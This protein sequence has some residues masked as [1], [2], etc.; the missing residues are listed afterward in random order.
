MSVTKHKHQII[1]SDAH[2]T[3]DAITRGIS[4]DNSEKNLLIQGDHNS[5]KFTFA[6]PRYIDGHDMLLC[7]HVQVAYINTQTSGRS[8]Q[9]STGVYLV[10]DL[11]LH[12]S[13]KDYLQC[14]WVI[15]HNATRYE[16]ALNFM[17]ILSCMEGETVT[18]RWK[19]NVFEGIHIAVSL[20]SDLVFEDE[21]VDII[22]QWKNSVMEYFAELVNIGMDAK[23][24]NVKAELHETLTNE[25]T[26]LHESFATELTGNIHTSI[27]EVN[28][29]LTTEVDHMHNAIDTFDDILETEI[30]KMDGDIDVLK[31]RMD[32]FTALGEGSTT[33]D[34]ELMDIRVGAD[35]KTYAN[36]G[37]AVRGQFNK[38]AGLSA[39][40]PTFEQ[41]TISST[42][43]ENTENVLNRIR[44]GYMRADNFVS[45]TVD[46]A[47]IV[48]LFQYNGDF[49][50][51]S[52]SN[53]VNSLD[54]SMLE[55]D[56][57]YIR[58]A[59]ARRNAENIT[60]DVDTGFTMTSVGS[61]VRPARVDILGEKHATLADRLKYEFDNLYEFFRT[62]IDF[63][64][65]SITANNGKNTDAMTRVR[66]DYLDANRFAVKI[67]SEYK[68]NLFQYTGA[69]EF[70]S[71]T[72]FTS[73]ISPDILQADC[74]YIR[75]VVC[76]SDDGAM[77]LED[78]TGFE[79]YIFGPRIDSVA[80]SE[81]K[82]RMLDA[83]LTI[84]TEFESGTIS[85]TDG[86]NTDNVKRIRSG[87][88]TS[89]IDGVRI[90]PYYYVGLF[91]YDVDYKFISSS[92]F[93]PNVPVDTIQE[94]CVH[95]RLVLTRADGKDIYPPE[96][97]HVTVYG[98]P[99]TEERLYEQTVAIKRA[100]PKR[101][102]ND[103]IMNTAYSTIGLAPINT[104]EHFH[105]AAHL[106]F[107]SLKGDVR[108]TADDELIMCHDAG[109]TLNADGRIGTYNASN[110]IPILETNYTDLMTLEYSADKISLG[111]YSKVC[112][113]D[114]FIRICKET[115]KIAYITL[116]E[117][118]ILPLVRG[119]IGTLEKYRM[120]NHC[121]INSYTLETLKE[122]RRYSDS[123]PLS[124][125]IS[126]GT[127]LTKDIVDKVVPLGN[128]I[129]TMFLYPTDNPDE[130]WEQSS[131]ALYYADVNDVQIHMAQ[132][133][134]YGDYSNMNRKGVQG[135]HLMKPFLAYNRSDV[136]FTVTVESRKAWF[137][138]ILNSTRYNADIS[139]NDGI[140]T[141]TNIRNNGSGY[142]Y[143]D[144]LPALWLNKLPFQANVT[145]STNP[146]CTVEVKNGAV[147][148][149]TN[150]VNGTYYVHVNI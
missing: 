129:I 105:L 62:D 13:K 89:K 9:Y 2:F 11:E 107:N 143:D 128:S 58:I 111:H 48:A 16:G 6:I 145:C 67:G 47:F 35:G 52:T 65:G 131:E 38:L 18:Y 90:H 88:L 34:A 117:N 138:N 144:G 50:F 137:G 1:D 150:N 4:N 51:L 12:P 126:L 80:Y 73:Y 46:Q 57:Q 132:V 85:S 14:S 15:S 96:G 99:V 75:F 136:Q 32:T 64:M 123:I 141:L 82:A 36:A 33:G 63:E 8:K 61:S 106:G 10:S 41:G 139:M 27:D 109:F 113:F 28:K 71:S 40:A 133:S 49:V 44:T 108:I 72:G 122:V 7:N 95:I 110:S 127:P 59:V 79:L 37:D 20:D 115:G 84:P 119:V 116:R 92:G 104:A 101:R 25:L 81:E 78:D 146:N 86:S 91:Q 22:E 121:V 77:T 98:L 142:G 5:E 54:H 17:L 3:I 19:T 45:S 103:E 118:N 26:E 148:L 68:V 112:D 114:T 24:E 31:S 135:F 70:I 147:I 29:T 76:K 130:L 23:A 140:V 60:P 43:G 125:V 87:Y 97:D 120:L 74:S 39:V 21:Y 56:C 55:D 100:M 124:M 53:W 66:T 42:T 30:T 69:Y 134:D 93:L 83:F 94:N 102:F 149:N